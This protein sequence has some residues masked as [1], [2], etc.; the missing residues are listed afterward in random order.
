MRSVVRV[1]YCCWGGCLFICSE[2]AISYCVDAGLVSV[3]Y[4]DA[5]CC[6]VAEAVMH[7][8]SMYGVWGADLRSQFEYAGHLCV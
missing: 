5:M 6:Y 1:S 2:E 8:V 3:S 7:E 4:I